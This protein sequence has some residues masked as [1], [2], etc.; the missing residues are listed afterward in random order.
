LRTKTSST[1]ILLLTSCNRIKQ[2]LLSLSINAQ[3]IKE[4]FSVIIVDSSTPNL[5]QEIACQMHHLEDPYNLVKPHNYC[6]DVDLLYDAHQYFPN[7]DEFKVIHFNP[8]LKKQMGESTSV[9]LGLTQASLMG[10]RKTDD[11]NFC[12]KLTG[13]SIL[14]YDILSK[15]S[16]HLKEKDVMVWHRQNIG[17]FERSTRIFG[18]RPEILSSYIVKEGWN[19]WVDDK[20][21]IF[22]MRISKFLNRHKNIKVNYTKNDESGILLEGGVGMQQVNG[23]EIIEEFIETNNI[24]TTATPW[25]KEFKNGGIW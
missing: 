19:E 17:G 25:L 21:G 23:R 20:T 11:K 10:N 15:L 24:D 12:L 8:R 3:I 6:N 13:T 1:N 18:C 14:K 9:A 2:V 16:L 7:I 5:N 4:K 22:E